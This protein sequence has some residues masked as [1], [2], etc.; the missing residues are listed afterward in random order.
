M[1]PERAREAD[2]ELAAHLEALRELLRVGGQIPAGRLLGLPELPDGD[3]WVD[4]AGAAALTGVKP[5]TI[6]AWLARRGPKRNPFPQPRRLLYRLYWRRT[7]I[8]SWRD[9][10]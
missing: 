3:C 10:A 6:S 2:V 1:A 4:I 7:V 9:R 5:R 8:E